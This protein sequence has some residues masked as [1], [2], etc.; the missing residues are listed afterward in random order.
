MM[1][2]L[3]EPLSHEGAGR[4]PLSHEGAGKETPE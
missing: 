1:R 2:V 3:G 4:E